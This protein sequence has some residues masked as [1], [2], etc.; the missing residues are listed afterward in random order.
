MTTH[1]YLLEIGLEDMPAH[2][3][4]PSVRQ[5]HDRMAAFLKDNRLAFADI[6]E[7]A[8]PRRLALLVSGLADKQTDEST[9]NR[10]PAMK[11]AKDADGNWTR[12]AQGFARGQGG[13]V[14][15]LEERDVKGTPYVFYQKNIIGQ[16]VADVL[17]KV[18]EIIEAMTF[19]T[20]MHWSHYDFEYIRPIHWFVSL[21][22]DKIVPFKILDVEAGRTT[23]GHRFLGHAVDL[24]TAT[25]YED[26][27]A[28]QFVIVDEQKRGDVIKAQVKQIADEHGWRIVLNRDLFEEVT[29]LV[30]YPTAFA[31][32]FDKK[33][34]ELPDA[35]LITSMR[36]NQR[37]FYV[38]DHDGQL[39]PDFVAVRNGNREYLEN[40]VKGN[41]KV[42]VARLE[43]AVFFY[44]EDQQ[45]SIADYV[46]KLKTV[47]F[48]DKIGSM[49]E[50]MQRVAGIARYLGKR[51]DLSEAEL[52]D[53]DRAAHIYKFD[54]VTSMV[55]EFPELQGTMGEIYANLAGE[56]EDVAKAIREHYMPTSADG[57]LPA[58]KIGSVLAIAD[59][60]DTIM[61]FFGAGM[62]PSG[63]NDPYALRRQAYGIIRIL[64]DHKWHFPLL[65]IQAAIVSQF[66]EKNQVPHLHLDKVKG[67]ND[68]FVD[69]VKQ[70]FSTKDTRHDIVDAVTANQDVD[71]EDMFA[72]ANVLTD[73]VDKESF[74]PTVEALTRVLHLARKSKDAGAQ[75]DP[76]LFQNPS[77]QKLHDAVE[78]LQADA[79]QLSIAELYQRLQDLRPIINEY[80][81]ENMVMDKDPKIR[82]NRLHQLAQIRDIAK[83]FGNLDGLI[84]K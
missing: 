50:K 45:H 38:T 7:Y 64:Q 12:A 77:E 52:A 8:T 19:P 73:Q 59:K 35:V 24:Q 58:S 26:A 33:Y 1:N 71:P 66:Q 84:V 56:K 53:L 57:K 69:R 60:M 81:E 76:S 80:F 14:D 83:F 39:L 43:D 28:D 32:Q 62:V 6:K 41:E 16:P 4:V 79:P 78:T 25:D 17:P 40:V 55:G 48:H 42:L 15:D 72:A 51:F 13:T 10:G 70:F 37:Y 30:E 46:E 75:V 82:D 61:T 63:S 27:L 20:R 68:F 54:L 34:L 11:I 29:N 36:D 65:R 9:E 44:E 22:D 3:V 47:M 5:L 31:G 18:T 2:V 23:Q 74:K 49:Y 21:L 67:L